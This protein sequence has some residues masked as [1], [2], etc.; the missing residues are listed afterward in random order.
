[1]VNNWRKN[2]GQS[3]GLTIEGLLA[4]DRLVGGG[5]DGKK[6][7]MRI[8]KGKKEGFVFI[9][10]FFASRILIAGQRM[11]IGGYGGSGF[12]DA[13]ENEAI[14]LDWGKQWRGDK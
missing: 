6:F 3:R 5:F 2:I 14:L 12:G 13:K 1:M 9:F 11:M 8:E 7:F 4:V 10:L